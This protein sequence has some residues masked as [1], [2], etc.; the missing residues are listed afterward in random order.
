MATAAADVTARFHLMRVPGGDWH[1]RDAVRD[2]VYARPNYSE[3][4]LRA[5]CGWLNQRDCGYRTIRLP[6]DWD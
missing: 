6:A 3:A 4:D 5:L 1:V 2:R